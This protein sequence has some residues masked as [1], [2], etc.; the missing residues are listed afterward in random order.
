MPLEQKKIQCPNLV[1]DK[2]LP[3]APLNQNFYVKKENFC[4]NSKKHDKL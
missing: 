1:W 2:F 4:K 3:G